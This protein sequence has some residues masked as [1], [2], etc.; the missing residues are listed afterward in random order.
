MKKSTSIAI[1]IC[2]L[3]AIGGL[4]VGSLLRFPPSE[5]QTT[6]KKTVTKA[7]LR[8]KWTLSAG[9]SGVIVGKEKGYFSSRNLDLAIKSG[10][11]ELDPIKLVASGADNFG[12]VGGDRLLLA[13]QEGV[14]VVAIGLENEHSFVVFI[15]L[16]KSD[17]YKPKDFEGKTVGVHHDDTYTVYQ[18]LMDQA[19]VNR[20]K[21]KEVSVGWD[22]APLLENIVDVYP[23]Y[24]INQPVILAKRGIAVN[25]IKPWEYGTEFIGNVYITSEQFLKDHPDTVQAFV[26]GLIDG[27]NYVFEHP[28]ESVD[29]VVSQVKELKKDEELAL[30]QALIP[31][32]HKS[33]FMMINAKNFEETQ[34]IMLKQGL[35]EKSLNLDTIYDAS[36]VKS[37]YENVKK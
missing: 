30:L 29:I 8:L 16:A 27:W 17:I 32:I 14:P 35:L 13:R 12:I 25:I 34:S 19:G 10:G 4:L 22:V 36:F 5:N 23:S 24:I 7:S 33:G 2:V 1:I 20:E 11:P 28:E 15:S 6:S 21:I 3:V 9:F 18:A 31:H 37:Y 26:S